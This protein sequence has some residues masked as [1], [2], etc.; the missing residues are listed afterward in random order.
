[1]VSFVGPATRSEFVNERLVPAQLFPTLVEAT[2]A[3]LPDNSEAPAIIATDHPVF[4][5]L[6]GTDNPFLDQVSIRRY[7]PVAEQDAEPSDGV[8]VIAAL[9]NGAPL[10]YEHVVGDGRVVTL[11][12][13]AGPG[14]LDDNG[15][16]TWNN[17][18]RSPSFPVLILELQAYVTAGEN[19]S[20]SA[21]VGEAITFS[22]DPNLY[23]EQI[24]ITGPEGNVVGLSAT[25]SGEGDARSLEA[26]F[27]ETATPG[28]Y[29][30]EVA[31][32]SADPEVTTRAFNVDPSESDLAV[33]DEEAFRASLAGV[34]SLTLR[35]GGDLG[36]IEAAATGS[37]LR[38][39]L[40][41]LLLLVLVIEQWWASR[42]SY[43]PT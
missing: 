41:G 19:A 39:L 12:T 23:R 3:E 8:N 20:S 32:A 5:I 40:I 22:L 33:A 26:E 37:S 17:W 4:S 30:I 38:P 35:D 10:V 21:T 6:A 11:L 25:P 27:G 42:L 14:E 31:Q 2:P 7:L 13:S 28:V 15:Q 16:S 24:E 9:R 43:P 18:A 1:M 36:W 29:R 34:S